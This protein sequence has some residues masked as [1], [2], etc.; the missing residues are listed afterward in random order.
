MKFKLPKGEKKSTTK[1]MCSTDA[2]FGAIKTMSLTQK[3]TNQP[4]VE[5]DAT[6]Y[7]FS[8]SY[9]SIRELRVAFNFVN[10]NKCDTN[11]KLRN[12]VP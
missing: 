5:S 6:K 10:E 12:S 3:M 11:F 4:S 9:K 8:S 2:F 1:V 7:N